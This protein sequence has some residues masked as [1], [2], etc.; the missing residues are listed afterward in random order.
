M[1]A[2]VLVFTK[3]KQRSVVRFHKQK[4]CKVPKFK[5]LCTQWEQYSFLKKCSYE[6]REIFK[7]G[8]TWHAV[9]LRCAL[10]STSN[11]KLG[12]AAVMVF[13]DGRVTISETAQK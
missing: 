10:T 5:C 6:W 11:E 7:K 4:M 9:H 12:E 1:N 13:K 2:P 8:W 3:D